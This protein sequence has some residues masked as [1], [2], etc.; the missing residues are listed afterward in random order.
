VFPNPERTLLPGI[1]LTIRMTLGTRHGAFLLP[2]SAIQRYND[3]AYVYVVGAGDKIAEK[4]VE[5]GD[6]HGSEWIVRDGL[7][8]GEKVVVSGIQQASGGEKVKPVA[9][10]SKEGGKATGEAG[11]GDG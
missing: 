1:L 9:E 4:R 5:L 6:Q 3:G 2:H 7:A 8:A 10:A 11:H